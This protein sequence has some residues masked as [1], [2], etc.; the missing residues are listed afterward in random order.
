MIDTTEEITS[1]TPKSIFDT[2]SRLNEKNNLS[3]TPFAKKTTKRLSNNGAHSYSM[4]D[5]PININEEEILMNDHAN[6]NRSKYIS[7]KFQFI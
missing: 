5:L 3:Q 2:Q 6:I 7:K 4:K 1:Q